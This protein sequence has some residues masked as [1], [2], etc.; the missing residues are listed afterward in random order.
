MS[1]SGTLDPTESFRVSLFLRGSFRTYENQFYQK[2]QGFLTELWPGYRNNLMDQLRVPFLRGWWSN[3][4]GTFGPAFQV[5][6]DKE[7]KA[8]KPGRSMLIADD[9]VNADRNSS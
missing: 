4:R 2:E 3:H 8:T 7:I 6:V 5:F 1:G 9:S